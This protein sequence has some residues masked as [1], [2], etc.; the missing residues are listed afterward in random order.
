MWESS[1]TRVTVG[2]QNRRRRSNNVIW[3]SSVTRVF[4]PRP[5]KADGQ[6][7]D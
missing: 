4:N 3:G 7:A 1:V 6:E 5:L 2:Q